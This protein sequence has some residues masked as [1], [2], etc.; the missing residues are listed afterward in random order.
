MK[1]VR[2]SEDRALSIEKLRENKNNCR[3]G[4]HAYPEIN[5][6]IETIKNVYVVDEIYDHFDEGTD[7]CDAALSARG[8]LD[9]V[10]SLDEILFPEN[11]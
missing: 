1:T 10:M 7:A 11:S 9:G 4:S 6:M 8:Y 5:A 3:L 2:T